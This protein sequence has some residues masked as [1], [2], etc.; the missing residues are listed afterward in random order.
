MNNNCDC[1][2]I[3]FIVI[4]SDDRQLLTLMCVDSFLMQCW[5]R[6]N[7]PESSQP[8]LKA[9]ELRKLTTK[10]SKPSNC[11]AKTP[12]RSKYCVKSS[13][14]SNSCVKTSEPINFSVKT[15]ESISIVKAPEPITLI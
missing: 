9:M 14:P 1:M 3:F 4:E 15:S 13:E 12:E 5:D 8:G 7:V 2:R 10:T 6:V 11:C